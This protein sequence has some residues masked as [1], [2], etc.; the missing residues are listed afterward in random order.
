MTSTRMLLLVAA[1]VAAV[2]G[3][4]AAARLVRLVRCDSILSVL[5]ASAKLW[6]A[7]SLLLVTAIGAGWEYDLGRWCRVSRLGR[8]FR[9]AAAAVCGL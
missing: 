3:R 8:L 5:W 6:R 2:A 4:V 7:Q 1:A 9:A